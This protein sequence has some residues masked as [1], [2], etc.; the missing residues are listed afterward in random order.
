MRYHRS[1]A[2]IGSWGT[3]D[4]SNTIRI[5]LPRYHTTTYIAPI[6]EEVDNVYPELVIHDLEGKIQGVR[7][8]ELAP[9]LL[10]EVQHEHATI[11]DQSAQLTAQSQHAAAQDVEIAELKAQ[12]AEIRAALTEKVTHSERVVQR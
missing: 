1:A 5:G 11:A 4:E 3:A 12:L 10:N 9:M 2:G 6:A 7:Y 8:D